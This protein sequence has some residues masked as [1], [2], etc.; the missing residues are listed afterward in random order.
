MVIVGKQH[1]PERE[2]VA[3]PE[4]LLMQLQMKAATY[5]DEQTKLSLAINH[6]R[7]DAADQLR[8]HV[9]DDRGNLT[10]IQAVSNILENAFDNPN[11]VAEAES[12][13][14]TIQPG[15]RDFSSN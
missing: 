14:T 10:N 8:P 2:K 3:D 5:S 1:A 9:R 4:H 11:D 15:A 7:G 12:R 13:I 6:L